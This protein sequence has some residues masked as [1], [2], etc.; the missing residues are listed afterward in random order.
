MIWKG[1][2]TVFAWMLMAL[3]GLGI[4]GVAAH[5]VFPGVTGPQIV[6]GSS[7]WLNDG[8]TVN[9]TTWWGTLAHLCITLCMFIW[10]WSIIH[11]MR[12]MESQQQ[13]E[14]D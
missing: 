14:R 5:F 8:F 12:R 2:K 11:D 13:P 9:C 3:A 4:I 1:I 6:C 10:G 7:P